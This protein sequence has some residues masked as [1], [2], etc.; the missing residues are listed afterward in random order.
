MKLLP[1][2][3]LSQ[4]TTGRLI[5]LLK[6]DISKLVL[7]RL[8]FQ[9]EVLHEFALLCLPSIQSIATLS[10]KVL[11]LCSAVWAL[12]LTLGMDVVALQTLSKMGQYDFI[13]LSS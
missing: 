2:R 12:T 4:S 13:A 11:I 6:Q 3:L 9:S 10:C 5:I 1:N 7:K 8:L